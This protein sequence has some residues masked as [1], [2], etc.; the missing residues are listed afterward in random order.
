MIIRLKYS[1]HYCMIIRTM[2]FYAE[3]VVFTVFPPCYHCEGFFRLWIIRIDR[4]S[5]KHAKQP[6]YL[7]MVFF[8]MFFG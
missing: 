2:R 8:W 1:F 5:N 6:H 3:L 4:M 7:H